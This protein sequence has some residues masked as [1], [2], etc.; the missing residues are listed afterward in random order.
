MPA[1]GRENLVPSGQKKSPIKYDIPCSP[2]LPPNAAKDS[3]VLMPPN[4]PTGNA[5]SMH[6]ACRAL[7]LIVKFRSD[8]VQVF[9]IPPFITLMQK[10]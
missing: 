2:P 9:E 4:S 3:T 10:L 1:P 8:F 5:E 7:L 6:L